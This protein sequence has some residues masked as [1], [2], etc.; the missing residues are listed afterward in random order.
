ML[1][2]LLLAVETI[3]VVSAEESLGRL[4]ERPL[5]SY[6]NNTHTQSSTPSEPHAGPREKASR[7]MLCSLIIFTSSVHKV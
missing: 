3:L 7:I 2:G 4:A 1:A 6:K 5:Y